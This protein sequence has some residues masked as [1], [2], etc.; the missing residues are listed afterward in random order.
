MI[1]GRGVQ[2]VENESWDGTVKKNI[3]IVLNVNH[4]DIAEEVVQ[5]PH[6]NQNF[7]YPQIP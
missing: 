2:F 7:T 1:I 4:D 5:K 3:K 6:A